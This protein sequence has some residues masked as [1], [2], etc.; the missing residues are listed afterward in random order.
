MRHLYLAG[1]KWRSCIFLAFFRVRVILEEFGQ[2]VG[3]TSK[4]VWQVGL[5]AEVVVTRCSAGSND[6]HPSSH[7]KKIT[8]TQKK[9]LLGAEQ[10]RAD[11]KGL[12][13]AAPTGNFTPK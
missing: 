8:Y 4:P 9:G 5:V 12:L 6:R 7:K 2:R 11:G 10:R 3:E 1:R 13:P